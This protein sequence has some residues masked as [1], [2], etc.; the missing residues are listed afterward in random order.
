MLFAAAVG[1]AP[2]LLGLQPQL[3]GTAPMPLDSFPWQPRFPVV[4]LAQ[5]RVGQATGRGVTAP[6]SNPQPEGDGS[7]WI[8]VPLFHSSE[9]Q[10]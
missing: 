2:D 3:W 5:S 1:G 10:F 6:E 4:E 8:N 9:G 7:W